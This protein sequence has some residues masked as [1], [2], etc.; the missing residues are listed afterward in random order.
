M[1]NNTQL[2]NSDKAPRLTPEKVVKMLK[3]KGTIV[4]IAQAEEILNFMNKMANIAVSNY[5]DQHNTNEDNN[6]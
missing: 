6:K 1:N 3:E 4:T 2:S 5:L